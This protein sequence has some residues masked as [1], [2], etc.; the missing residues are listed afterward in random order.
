MLQLCLKSASYSLLKHFFYLDISSQWKRYLMFEL[1]FFPISVFSSHP[2]TYRV[3]FNNLISGQ[4]IKIN[5]ITLSVQSKLHWYQEDMLDS[6]LRVFQ[7]FKQARNTLDLFPHTGVWLIIVFSD[8]QSECYCIQLWK[9]ALL[10][11]D[12]FILP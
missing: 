2:Q 3:Y 9:V 5:I 11:N 10:E 7:S 6:C 12:C 1:C 8:F 4:A